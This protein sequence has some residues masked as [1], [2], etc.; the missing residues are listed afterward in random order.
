M[1]YQVRITAEATILDYTDRYSFAP[2]EDRKPRTLR[3]YA[4]QFG[5]SFEGEVEDPFGLKHRISLAAFT[6]T[7]PEDTYIKLQYIVIPEGEEFP[8]TYSDA[9]TLK[10]YT[11]PDDTILPGLDRPPLV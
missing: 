9:I 5:G 4:E 8:Q 11:L 6:Q 10:E 1:G 2:E 7:I 3:S